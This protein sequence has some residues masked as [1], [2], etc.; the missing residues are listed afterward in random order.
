MTLGSVIYEE[1]KQNILIDRF[2]IYYDEFDKHSESVIRCIDEKYKILFYYEPDDYD[3]QLLDKIHIGDK[4]TSYRSYEISTH[5][6]DKYEK[7]HLN[8]LFT[9]TL[10][11]R[12]NTLCNYLNK[13]NPYEYKLHHLVKFFD[14]DESIKEQIYF[15]YGMLLLK[16]KNYKEDKYSIFMNPV[17]V[18]HLNISP[19]TMG[20]FKHD[21]R[22]KTLLVYM[23]GGIGDNI[24]YSRF[25]RQLCQR[26]H[27]VIFLV[28]DNLYWI[29]S[30]IYKDIS[31]LRIV[32][33]KDRDTIGHFDY[34]INV[35]RLHHALGLDYKDI[36]VDYIEDLPSYPNDI[37]LNENTYII[38]WKGCHKNEHEL[39]NRGI[40]LESCIPLFKM[41]HIHWI[42]ITKDIPPNEQ[43][44]LDQYNV[45][46]YDLDEPSES[47]RH[48]ISLLK[49][50]KGV[51]STDTSLAHIC[52][53]LNISCYT[54]LSAGCDWRWTRD[55]TTN[56]YPTMNLIRQDSPFDWSNVIEQ[57]ITTLNDDEITNKYKE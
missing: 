43:H 51:I 17:Y 9:I 3:K 14:L 26:D 32:S 25:I 57:L 53:T 35:C 10:Y 7:K 42:S 12:H 11:F 18:P 55:K 47:F 27:Q 24:M 36:Y 15:H 33:Y 6:A 41:K 34:H 29:Y 20:F 31:N 1:Y 44:I 23:S 38:N 4:E 19:T 5:L 37:C 40:S 46:C 30:H 22:N 54:L 28:Y 16:N 52:G 2:S 50:V 8:N 21:D 49:C 56:W 45:K 39:H 48:S 13:P